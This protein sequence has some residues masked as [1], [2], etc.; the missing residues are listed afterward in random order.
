[1]DPNYSSFAPFSGF[2]YMPTPEE[3]YPEMRGTMQR[4]QQQQQQRGD[5]ERESSRMSIQQPP[6]PPV[7]NRYYPPQRAMDMSDGLQANSYHPARH[8]AISSSAYRCMVRDQKRAKEMMSRNG[9]YS[10]FEISARFSGGDASYY[11]KEAEGNRRMDP[12]GGNSFW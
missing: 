5:F 4:E 12:R 3:Y 8:Q 7:G 6:Q 11:P 1:M 2:S 10:P 9:L